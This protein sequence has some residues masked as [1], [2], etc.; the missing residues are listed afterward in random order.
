LRCEECGKYPIYH[1]KVHHLDG[2]YRNNSA[3]NL[4]LV[5]PFC[6][7]HF[8]LRFDREDIFILKMRGLSNAE[9]GRHLGISRERVRQLYNRGLARYDID[10]LVKLALKRQEELL[11]QEKLEEMELEDELEDWRLG[12]ITLS[13][14]ELRD[15][16]KQLKRL[17]NGK[18]KRRRI[19]EKRMRKIVLSMVNKATLKEGGKRR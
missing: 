6:N 2:D 9:I 18:S 10:N 19:G 11:E 1:P 4:T 3:S 12:F 8:I 14:K 17:R 15:R 13:K 5:C 7:T 16:E